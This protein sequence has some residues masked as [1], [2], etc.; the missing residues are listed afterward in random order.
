[1][2]NLAI[3]QALV[4]EP[5]KAFAELDQRPR[6]WWPLLVV[7]ISSALLSVWYVSV[8]D[9]AWLT[10]IQLRNS[11]FGQNMTDAEI[12]RAAQG[13]GTQRGAQMAIGGLGTLFGIVIMLLISALYY[14]LAAKIT[15]VERGFR[16]WLA[17]AA[18]S[19]MPTVLAVIAAAVVLLTASSNQIGQEAL[20]PLSVN[21]LL[22]QREP[23]EPGYA[24]FSNMNLLQFVALYLAAVGVREWSGRSWTYAI[25][26]SALPF[27]LVYGVWAFF[28]LR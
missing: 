13:A 12:A 3:L 11:A 23:G 8:V 6:F 9:L 28:A 20:Q 1:M 18:W 16:H 17:L 27:V 25:V 14:L 4:F 24:L 10:D 2:N 5:R 26:F 21:A 19:T 15:G 7:A 22:L